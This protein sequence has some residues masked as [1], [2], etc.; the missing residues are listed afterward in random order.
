MAKGVHTSA[1][2]LTW[3]FFVHAGLFIVATF[4]TVILAISNDAWWWPAL[5]V[6]GFGLATHGVGAWWLRKRE[7]SGL[8]FGRDQ[9]PDEQRAEVE[10]NRKAATWDDPFR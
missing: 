2:R 5:I 4:G 6:W 7:R 1:E 8:G 9:L 10:W 3:T